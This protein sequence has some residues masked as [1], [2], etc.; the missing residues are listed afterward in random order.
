[1]ER[2]LASLREQ[3]GIILQTPHLFSGTI[4]DNIL[5]GDLDASDEAVGGALLGAVLGWLVGAK[6]GARLGLSLGLQV[7]P[8]VGPRL[9]RA[10]GWLVG[11]PL[12]LLLGLWL[13]L[14]VGPAVGAAL[15]SGV[16]RGVGIGL[17]DVF[18][19]AVK[20][21]Y[22]DISGLSQYRQS[23]SRPQPRHGPVNWVLPLLSSHQCQA[24]SPPPQLL[25]PLQQLSPLSPHLVLVPSSRRYRAV[26]SSQ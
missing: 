16:G 8:E 24:L 22:G 26:T 1:M 25:A 18:S 19:Q 20:R 7:G 3:M 2:T 10:V 21:V 5:Y 23:S 12:G 9:G 14:E 4:R 15:G 11:V 6:L 13:G 17:G